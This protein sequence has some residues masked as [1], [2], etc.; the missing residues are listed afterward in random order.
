MPCC[1]CHCSPCT[2][3]TTEIRV[4]APQVQVLHM[5]GTDPNCCPIKGW[6]EALEVTSLTVPA[7]GSSGTIAVC[8]AT[9]YPVGTCVMLMDASGNRRVVKVTGWNNDRDAIYVLSYA[10]AAAIGSATLS[11]NINSY[12]LALCPVETTDAGVLCDRDYMVTAEAFVQPTAIT[13]SGGTVK[14]VFDK[15]QTLQL[16]MSIYVVGAG[17]M[18]VSVPPSGTFIECGTEFYVYNLG[19]S[20]NAGAGTTIAAGAAAYP[21]HVP[22]VVADPDPVGEALVACFSAGHLDT[23]GAIDETYPGAI[24]FTTAWPA[25]LHIMWKVGHPTGETG[26]YHAHWQLKLAA[27]RTN[28]YASADNRKSD[29]TGD[30]DLSG[31]MASSNWGSAMVPNVAAGTWVAWIEKYVQ[32]GAGSISLDTWRI[33]VI[34]HRKTL[35]IVPPP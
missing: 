28:N 12:P 25:D 5:G 33:N 26:D 20:G 18:Q 31:Y 6:Y 35:T 10:N 1:T 11:G 7:A 13:S 30:A 21:D 23:T 34:A 14:I 29:A 15:P 17:Y 8:D 9:Q 2:C 32:T 16:G 24:T 22:A 27:T 4:P 3:N 19:T